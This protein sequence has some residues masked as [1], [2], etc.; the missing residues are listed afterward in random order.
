MYPGW[1]IGERDFTE[2]WIIG[3]D[4]DHRY[5]TSQAEGFWVFSREGGVSAVSSSNPRY[6]SDDIVEV[7][8]DVASGG[9]F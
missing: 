6:N 4:N 8:Y 9:P 3:Q 7:I 1:G 2:Y 5:H